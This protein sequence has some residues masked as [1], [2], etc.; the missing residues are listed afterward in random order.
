[1]AIFQS[2][3]SSKLANESRVT[4]S[5]ALESLTMTPSATRQPAGTASI[6]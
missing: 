1:M 4:M 3:I 6:L 5:S 2:I